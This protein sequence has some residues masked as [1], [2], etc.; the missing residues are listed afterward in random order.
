M[1]E[2]AQDALIEYREI[3]TAGTLNLAQQAA[4]AGVKRFIF[5]SS[6]KVNGEFSDI[7]KPLSEKVENP[8]LDPYG[9]SKY[10]AEIGLKKIAEETGLEVVVIRPPLVYGPGVK[11]NFLS[12]M[13]WTRKGVPLPLGRINNSRSL[14]FRDN[15]VDLILTCVTH[16]GAANR[17]F[18]VSDDH[19]VSVTQL[20][21][22][23]ASA[24]KVSSRLFPVPE[25]WL[26]FAARLIGKPEIASR[27]CQNL[28]VDI[29]QTKYALNWTPPYSFKQ[30]I[31]IT[32][33]NYLNK[34]DVI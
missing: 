30:G 28:Q 31:E 32:V 12:M 33:R 13:N 4:Q 16:L 18:M 6:V 7:G 10:E 20:L 11:A 34:E 2:S 8:P 14:V 27:L 21:K 23:I 25:T 26:V 9:L 17:T 24:M 29:S 5:L 15:L 3:N 22:T 1:N 19:D